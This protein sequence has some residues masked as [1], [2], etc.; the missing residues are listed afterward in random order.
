MTP[1]K[2][3]IVIIKAL[4][5]K[6]AKEIGYDKIPSKRYI[7]DETLIWLIELSEEMC[8]KHNI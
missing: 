4:I 1:E 3:M 2:Q 6:R 8:N 5:M 7:V